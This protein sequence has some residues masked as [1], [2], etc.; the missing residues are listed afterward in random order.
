MQA[1]AV[2][3]LFF[4]FVLLVAVVTMSEKA[5]A[6][7]GH[8]KATLAGGC[9]WCTQAAFQKLDGVLTVESGYTGGKGKNP[10]YDDYAQKGHV[11]A[12]EIT[13]DPSQVTF[14]QIL[15]LF[16]RNIDPTDGLGQF[17]DRGPHYRPVVFYHSEDQKTA[18]E[19]SKKMLATSGRLGR[20]IAVDILPATIFYPAE[21]YHQD[22]HQK[23]PARYRSY[24]MYSGRDSYFESIWGRS[25]KN[26]APARQS[27]VYSKPPSYELKNR[28][29]PLQFEVTQEDGTERPF[30]NEHWN[31]KKE[32]IYVDVVSGEPLFSSLDKFDSGTGWPSFSKPLEPNNIVERQ[33]RKLFMSR[34]EVR[35]RYADSHLGHVFPD[36]PAPNGLRYCMNSAAL[37]FIPKEDL[38][39]EG[40]G[41]Y[42]GLF[43]K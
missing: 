41:A 25:S 12:V 26:E 29:T 1:H 42:L 5:Q 27:R 35:S 4:V 40:Y 34:T 9:F 36:G 43:Q 39:K 6:H 30:Q 37:R 15:E 32:G 16:W 13:Y 11:E 20:P 23:S 2:D 19:R 7:R 14:E 31:N 24:R 3:L 38:E 21:E 17:V 28:L 8:E 10:T 18:A 22:Y 33:D